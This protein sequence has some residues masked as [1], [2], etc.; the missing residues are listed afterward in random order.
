MREPIFEEPKDQLIETVVEIKRTS[1]KT[2]GGNRMS[3]SALAVVGDGLGK[4]GTSL[5]KAPSVIEAIRKATRK[6]KEGMQDVVI[7]GD[8][9]TISHEIEVTLGATRVMLKPA[10]SGTGVRAGGPVRSVL[11]AA[12]I[13]NVVAKILGTN[14]KKQN[15][16]ATIKALVELKAPTER[17]K[18]RS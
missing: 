6:A 16:D 17:I 5:G 8:A 7:V 18:K 4:V 2:K 1:K 11:Q 3:F 12:G 9:R 10:P 14:G 15:V 13:Q